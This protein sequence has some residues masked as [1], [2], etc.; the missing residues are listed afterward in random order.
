MLN[1]MQPYFGA[2]KFYA[3]KVMILQQKFFTTK[4]DE[5]MFGELGVQNGV[6]GIWEG[7]DGGEKYEP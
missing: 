4:Q 3:K 6:F 2:W 5:F 7:G 1:C